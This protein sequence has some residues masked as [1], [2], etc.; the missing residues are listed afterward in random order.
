MRFVEAARDALCFVVVAEGFC[1]DEAAADGEENARA[2]EGFGPHG[3][4]QVDDADG[5]GEEGDEE[6]CPALKTPGARDRRER[7]LSHGGMRRKAGARVLCRG[8]ALLRAVRVHR[9]YITGHETHM[10]CRLIEFVLAHRAGE[11]S[12]GG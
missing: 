8:F 12:N 6:R 10:A 5:G 2:D 4:G 11:P 9:V 7:D 3:D 1:E